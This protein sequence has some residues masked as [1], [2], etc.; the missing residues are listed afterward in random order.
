MVDVESIQKKIIS[1]RNE[2]DWEQFHNPKNRAEVLS[3]EAGKLL[4]IF[5]WK[6]TEQSRN[7]TAEEQK[8]LILETSRR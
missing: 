4:E 2:Y 3:I 5:P 6:T 7:L 8:N 1:F